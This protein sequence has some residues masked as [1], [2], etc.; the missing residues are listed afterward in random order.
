MYI[1]KDTFIDRICEL[2]I[3]DLN[4]TEIYN[5]AKFLAVSVEYE[6]VPVIFV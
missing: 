3:P 5:L 2:N 6:S 1:S 4:Y